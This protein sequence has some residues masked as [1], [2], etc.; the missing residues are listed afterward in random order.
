M[1]AYTIILIFAASISAIKMKELQVDP[2]AK[3]LIFDVDGTLVH[4][5]P[6][7]YKAWVKVGEKYN[8]HFPED[9]FY[10]LAGVPTPGIAKVIIEKLDLTHAIDQLAE[11]KEDT[12]IGMIDEIRPVQKVVD[13]VKAYH[14]Q[15]PLAA[16]TGSPRINATKTIQTIGIFELFEV[17]V[18]YEDVENP[19]P[20][21]DTFL[22]CA[23]YLKV[24]PRFCQ[25]FEDGDPGLEAANKAGMIVTDVRQFI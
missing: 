8:F 15:L 24:E 11:E 18:T 9:L 10:E 25:V 17:L 23:D 22:K 21:P 19:K 13:L 6:L 20:A 1:E 3:A 2:K 16:G 12:Y 14:G 5:M 4:S 7:H